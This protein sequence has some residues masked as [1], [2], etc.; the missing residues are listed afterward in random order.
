MKKEALAAT[1]LAAALSETYRPHATPLEVFKMARRR[2]LKGQHVCLG[3][4]AKEAGISRG[5]LQRWVGNKDLLLDEILWSLAK[6]A[7]ER[8]V[9]ETPDSGIEHIIGVHRRFMTAILSDPALQQFIKNEQHYALRILTDTSSGV[10]K[11][12]VQLTAAHLRDQQTRGHISLNASAEELAEF[13][14]LANQA[15]I[16]TDTVSGRSPAIDKACAL[17]R[18]LLTKI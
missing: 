2:Y 7:F 15:I 5:T 9:C 16:Y 6:P 8:A 18:M 3:E 14:I 17:I 13:F 1:P 10:S 4:I 12:V 11:R